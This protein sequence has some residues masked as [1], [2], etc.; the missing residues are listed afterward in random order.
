MGCVPFSFRCSFLA[1][2]R[3]TV[4]V[5]QTGGM[6]SHSGMVCKLL[7]PPNPQLTEQVET[8]FCDLFFLEGSGLF[9]N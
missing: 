9:W 8:E 4:S 3:R 2:L 1:K 7:L 6:M 5:S